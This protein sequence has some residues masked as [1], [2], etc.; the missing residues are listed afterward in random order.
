MNTKRFWILS[1]IFAV[2]LTALLMVSP[3]QAPWYLAAYV[4]VVGGFVYGASFSYRT[5]DGGPDA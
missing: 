1:P 5:A 4:G 3:A 2:M